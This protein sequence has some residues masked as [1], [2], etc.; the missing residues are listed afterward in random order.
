M[1]PTKLWYVFLDK[2]KHRFWSLQIP[3]HHPSG[4]W[5]V[6]PQFLIILQPNSFP[7]FQAV[8]KNSMHFHPQNPSTI[9]K[10]PY[11]YCPGLR[12]GL[13]FAGSHYLQTIFLDFSR[14]SMYYSFPISTLLRTWLR[15]TWCHCRVYFFWK[16]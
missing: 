3:S 1:S 15:N 7:W 12:S 16:K 13:C 5:R 2:L 4:T 11:L 14:L 6:K 9:E 8:E 10:D